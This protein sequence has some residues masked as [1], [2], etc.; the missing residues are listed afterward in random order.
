MMAATPKRHHATFS[1]MLTVTERERFIALYPFGQCAHAQ[2]GNVRSTCRAPLLA[3]VRLTLAMRTDDRRGLNRRCRTFSP[4]AL[5]SIGGHRPCSGP[6]RAWMGEPGWPFGLPRAPS[7]HE[8]ANKLTAV[9][10]ACRPALRE[11]RATSSR[12]H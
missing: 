1:L 12:H 9:R 5:L 6:T 2:R 7:T 10:P 11:R 3:L 8:W 4:L